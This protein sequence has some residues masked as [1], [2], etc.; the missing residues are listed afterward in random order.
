MLKK[1]NYLRAHIFWYAPK[2]DAHSFLVVFFFNTSFK[3]LGILLLKI[4][5]VWTY[6]EVSSAFGHQP[7]LPFWR[8]SPTKPF[9]HVL[10]LLTAR[11]PEYNVHSVTESPVSNY[12][13]GHP[14]NCSCI[15]LGPLYANRQGLFVFLY[16]NIEFLNCFLGSKSSDAIYVVS[17]AKQIQVQ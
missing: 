11:H 3:I 7:S 4:G 1:N 14:W 13:T 10:V 9:A 5:N 2:P 15:F 16:Y 17:V 12:S 6:Q 8:M